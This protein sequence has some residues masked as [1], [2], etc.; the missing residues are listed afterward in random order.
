MYF[1]KNKKKLTKSHYFK[2]F[3]LDIFNE[4][5]LSVREVTK[6]IYVKQ[7]LLHIRIDY[8]IKYQ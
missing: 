4:F 7:N 5:F 6:R 1:Y 3:I 8:S 2:Q